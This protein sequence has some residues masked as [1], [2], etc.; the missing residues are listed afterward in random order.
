M[1]GLDWLG[2]A[3]AFTLATGISYALINWPKKRSSETT[4]N[5]KHTSERPAPVS[6]R[7]SS[8]PT[9]TKAAAASRSTPPVVMTPAA[10]PPAPEAK[11]ALVKLDYEEDDE[12]D[13]T[14]VGAH[15]ARVKR[16]RL[17]PPVQ[18]IVY[19][20]DAEN[21]EPTREELLFLVSATA[22]TDRGLRR[23]KNEDS[24]LVYQDD[25]LYVV[26]DGMGG[27]AGGAT[28]SQLAVKTI[29]DSFREKTFEGAA[30]ENIPREATEL[31]R[32]IQMAN[33]AILETAELNRELQGMGTT[34]CAARFSPN[35]KRV[36]LGH[37]GDSRCYR[38]RNGRLDQMTADHTMQSLGMEGPLGAQLS[39]AVGVWPTVPIDIVMGVPMA[40][41]V[42]LLCSDGL[43]KMLSDE[44]IGNVLR[45]ER[46]PAAIA[47]GLVAAANARGGKDNITVVII[48]VVG[49]NEVRREGGPAQSSMSSSA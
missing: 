36:Y 46:E 42:Y 9:S 4:A 20:E 27:C 18:K 6:V 1:D 21:D 45:S 40:G 10:S 31:A 24:L 22:Q 5:G 19:D 12:I 43:T 37:V 26:A 16:G 30:H 41:D 29:Y 3:S 39:R 15:G 47:N 28:A 25:N 13:P 14:R 44:V 17:Q 8:A 7:P 32:S 48:H 35:K 34:L 33:D 11:P 2:V 38:L 23:K 49:P